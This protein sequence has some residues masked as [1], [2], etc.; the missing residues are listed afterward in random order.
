MNDLEKDFST[1]QYAQDVNLIPNLSPSP[2]VSA[3]FSLHNTA[4]R[5]ETFGRKAGRCALKSIGYTLGGILFLALIFTLFLTWVNEDSIH[6]LW[7]D[8][9][10][11]KL[12]GYAEEREIN[13]M[14]K[15]NNEILQ[16]LLVIEDA[17]GIEHKPP[18]TQEEQVEEQREVIVA[19]ILLPEQE[20]EQVP[21]EQVP[22]LTTEQS[23]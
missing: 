20:Q 22:E 2:H 5:A 16:R 13:A 18:V 4:R 11:I 1:E 6:E 9:L 15:T 19:A 17:L 14:K 12:K 21:E 23:I 8:N 3:R 10:S 7:H